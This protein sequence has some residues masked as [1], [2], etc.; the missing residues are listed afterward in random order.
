MGHN[1]L[2]QTKVEV[3]LRT[4]HI[5]YLMD[6][7]FLLGYRGKIKRAVESTDF[8]GR[9]VGGGL[10]FGKKKSAESG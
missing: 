7:L 8:L 4:C 6:W 10:F 9:E 1:I 2:H 3:K 5:M